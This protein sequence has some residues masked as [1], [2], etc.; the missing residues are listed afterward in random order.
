MAC[1]VKITLNDGSSLT[2]KNFVELSNSPME[3]IAKA[4]FNN[5]DK[6]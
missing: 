5:D 2:F 3:G 1:D 4:L 6:R